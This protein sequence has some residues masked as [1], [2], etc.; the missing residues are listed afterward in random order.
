MGRDYSR[1]LNAVTT[2]LTVVLGG[3]TDLQAAA[4]TLAPYAAQTIGEKW[5][6]GEDKITVAQ[7]V[8]HAILGATL[9]YINGGD[10]TAGG[11]AAVASE[12]AANYLTSQLAEKYKDDPKYFVNGE[13]Q[14]N[15]LSEAEKAQIRDL[16]AG[17]GAVIGGA[18]GDSSYNA[19]LAGVIGQN[20]VEN[21][22]FS[23][24]DENYGKVVKENTKEKF[25]CPTGYICPIPEKTLGEKTLL[26]INDLTIRQLAAA[27]GAEYDPITKEHLTPKEI[28]EA[29]AAMLGL[30]FS[31]TLNGPIKLTDEAMANIGKKYGKDIAKIVME[32]EADFAGRVPV[33]P[34]DGYI[35]A[36][37]KQID[38]PLGKH[39]ISGEV[40]GRK[41]QKVISGGHNSDN[42]Y[43]VLNSNGGKVIGTP[44]Q[45]SKGIFD[46]K[47][48]LP[49]GSV[50]TKTVYDPKVY[51]DKKMA[52]MA[53]EAASKAIVNYGVNGNKIQHVI[54][55]GITFRVPISS[56]K[57]TN[58]VPSAFPIN[59]TSGGVK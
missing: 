3:Q 4:N 1:G 26:V 30:G 18:A 51:S 44:T 20:T 9:V 37:T 45:V 47:Y 25:P 5:G 32:P 8:S 35:N 56:Y 55:N 31:K 49:N 39:L 46:I 57:G 43:D 19:Q 28:Q 50:E 40:A 58:Y 41:N 34:R 10:P 48:Q 38:T 15:L 6:H 16:T 22:G 53:N 7:L 24:I 2:A 23:I 59:P 52:A 54:V 21:N 14:A 29:K 42:F 11:S 36:G 33:R 27:M 12:A 17:I 13:F